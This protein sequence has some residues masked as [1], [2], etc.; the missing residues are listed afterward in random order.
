MN[1]KKKFFLLPYPCKIAGIVISL[2]GILLFVVFCF[3]KHDDMNFMSYLIRSL[4]V[5]YVGV[6]LIG[7]SR[8]KR[9]DEF[10][11]YLR[12]NS[13]LISMLVIFGL[14]IVLTTIIIILEANGVIGPDSHLEKAFNEMTDINMVFCLYVILYAFRRVRY[15]Y[16]I[17]HEE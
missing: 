14:K 9:E 16:R 8:E 1:T 17:Q 12:T 15:N 3:L 7:F 13:A 4:F 11:L 6:Y 5:L 2:I 10:T